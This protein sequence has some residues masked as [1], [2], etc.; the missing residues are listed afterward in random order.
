MLSAVA[1]LLMLQR[2]AAHPCLCTTSGLRGTFIPNIGQSHIDYYCSVQL[3]N[4]LYM[5][6][7]RLKYMLK[8]DL[9][10]SRDIFEFV[11]LG[12]LNV[13]T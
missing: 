13:D 12:L 10:D 3:L 2:G 11:Y 9:H 7:R 1:D 6:Y 4:G 8:G 5:P